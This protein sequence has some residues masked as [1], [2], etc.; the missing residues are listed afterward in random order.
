ME[1]KEQPINS[2]YTQEVLEFAAVGV[3]FAGLMEQASA[4]EKRQFVHETVLILPQ[5]YLS[6][7]RLP[8]YLYSPE[9][10]YIEEF[11]TEE[12]Y[13][14][15]RLRLA[16]LLGEEDSFLSCQAEDMQYSDTP[17]ASFVSECMADVYQQTVNLLGILRDENEE[18]LPAAIGRC[19]FYFHTYTGARLLEAL[20][21]LHRVHT[22]LLSLT[23]DEEDYS[24]TEEGSE[25]LYEDLF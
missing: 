20:T 7:L 23:D 10:D 22:Q 4:F 3:K 1:S 6:T 11:V 15:V 17:L 21:A 13:E 24:D 8:D 18:A 16:G 9:E 19:L 5:L 2:L 14:T 25:K 12:T